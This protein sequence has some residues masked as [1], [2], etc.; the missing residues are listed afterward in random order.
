MLRRPI[1]SLLL[2]F[3]SLASLLTGCVNFPRSVELRPRGV[4]GVPG[5]TVTK[6]LVYTPADWPEPVR[7]DLYRPR[8]ARKAPAVLLIHGGGWTGKDGRWEMTLIA[9]KLAQ[10]GYVVLNVTY[11]LAPRWLYPAPVDDL[12]EAVKWLRTHAVEQGIDPTRIATFGYSAGGH[13][14]AMVG[15]L[16][17]SE[18]SHIRAVVAGGAPADLML[19]PGGTLV[20]QFLGGTRK[21][22]PQR[23]KEASPVNHIT[24]NSPPTFVFHG[25]KDQLVPPEHAQ[26]MLAALEKNHVAHDSY[27]VQGRD[28]IATFVFPANA[29]NAAIDF[30]DWHMR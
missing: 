12:R 4:V 28:H 29:V 13:L 10:R 14:A 30:L 7:G 2:P 18:N 23:F 3:V 26:A 5:F 1:S 21:Q 16:E 20:P 8:S 17:G 15:F 6:D 11:R 22:I 25:T 24:K 19:Y 27:W 9:R